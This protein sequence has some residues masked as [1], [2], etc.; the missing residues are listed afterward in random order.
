MTLKGSSGG[1]AVLTRTCASGSAAK[2][3]SSKSDS[4]SPMFGIGV[5]RDDGVAVVFSVGV[6]ELDTAVSG[7][8][9]PLCPGVRHCRV[10]QLD[11]AVSNC[12]TLCPPFISAFL[13]VVDKFRR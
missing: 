5:V 2:P 13:R 9:T 8:W 12:W 3:T 7:S 6:W 1:A 11:T 10:W 4:D